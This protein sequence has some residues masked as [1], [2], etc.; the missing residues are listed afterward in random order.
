M[1]HRPTWLLF[2]SLIFFA[3]AFTKQ[4]DAQT[5][6]LWRI[7]IINSWCSSVPINPNVPGSGAKDTQCSA[8]AFIFNS[9]TGAIYECGGGYRKTNVPDL[10][11]SF[12]GSCRRHRSPINGPISAISP[13]PET[14]FPKQRFQ[15]PDDT[16]STLYPYEGYY[17]VVGEDIAQTYFCEKG[18]N[19][20]LDQCSQAKLLD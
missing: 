12:G 8:A 14:F 18:A 2:F 17:W 19:S 10:P 3:L 5:Q 15:N 1:H 9:A 16:K 20:S 6:T 13:P 4:A 11:R 7:S